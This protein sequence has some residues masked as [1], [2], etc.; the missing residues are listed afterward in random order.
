M[1]D[2]ETQ[3]NAELVSVK[4]EIAELKAERSSYMEKYESAASGTF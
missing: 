3:V 4:M 1:C 2:M